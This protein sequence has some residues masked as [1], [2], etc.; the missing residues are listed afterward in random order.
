MFLI[1][2]VVLLHSHICISKAVSQAKLGHVCLQPVCISLCL[3]KW[4]MSESL[5]HEGLT[6]LESS[7]MLP[8]LNEHLC[9]I[10]CFFVSIW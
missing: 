5:L 1:I 9:A 4:S 8:A 6:K 2:E 7:V 10:T 3:D